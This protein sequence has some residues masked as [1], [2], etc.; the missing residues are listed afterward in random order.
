MFNIT[1]KCF[2]GGMPNQESLVL[3]LKAVFEIKKL[4]GIVKSLSTFGSKQ[5]DFQKR[6]SNVAQ[7]I[8]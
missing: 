8:F 3:N 1:T 4:R 2:S 7:G 5:H 6:F